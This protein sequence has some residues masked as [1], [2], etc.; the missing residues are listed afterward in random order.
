MTGSYRVAYWS[1]GVMMCYD[2]MT[3]AYRLGCNAVTR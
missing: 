3:D 1:N 2:P